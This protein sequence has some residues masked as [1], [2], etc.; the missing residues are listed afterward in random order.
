MFLRIW[1]AGSGLLDR[2]EAG[3]A[4]ISLSDR[5]FWGSVQ[6]RDLLYAL[7]DRWADLTELHRRCLEERLLRGPHPWESDTSG[8]EVE[9]A[10][11]DRLNRLH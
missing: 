11:H 10:A 3:A 4:L 6:E 9:L 8:K 2:D 5:V 1:A 7:R